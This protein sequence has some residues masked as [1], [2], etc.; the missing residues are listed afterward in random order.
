MIHCSVTAFSMMSLFEKACVI[1]E[2]VCIFQHHEETQINIQGNLN[3]P[4]LSTG[5]YR[6]EFTPLHPMYRFELTIIGE[7]YYFHH[8]LYYPFNHEP[9]AKVGLLIQVPFQL[10]KSHFRI[11]SYFPA[12]AL[13]CCGRISYIDLGQHSPK[14]LLIPQHSLNSAFR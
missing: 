10:V 12:V 3:D 14:F 2:L 13:I 8:T 4:F 9:R 5:R 6:V 11:V 7:Y 1:V